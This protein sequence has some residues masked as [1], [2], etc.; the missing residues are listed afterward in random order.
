MSIDKKA[1]L[2]NFTLSQKSVY[3]KSI[4]AD[5]IIRNFTAEEND[6][7]TEFMVKGL[8]KQGEPEIDLGKSMQL[9]YMKISAALVEPKLTVKELKEMYGAKDFIEEMMEVIEGKSEDKYD[10][11]GNESSPSGS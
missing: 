9:K 5:V 8:N 3:L 4:D 7:F 11:E 1:L 2:G 6:R 10:E